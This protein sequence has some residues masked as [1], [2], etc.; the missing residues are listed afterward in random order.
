MKAKLR[1]DEES[2]KLIAIIDKCPKGDGTFGAIEWEAGSIGNS[3]MGLNISPKALKA[4]DGQEMEV[5]DPEKLWDVQKD[6]C[7][8]L[9]SRVMQPFDTEKKVILVCGRSVGKSSS[10]DIVSL[11]TPGFKF[12]FHRGGYEDSMSTCVTLDNVADL[13]RLVSEAYGLDIPLTFKF[14]CQGL[15]RRN[16]W[17]TYLVTC[18]K[19]DL[20]V[21]YTDG[22]PAGA[23]THYPS[24]PMTPETCPNCGSK[25]SGGGT[26]L[27]DEMVS[28]ARVFY[29][30]GASISLRIRPKGHKIIY[31]TNCSA[32]P[33]QV[34]R[35]QVINGKL[36][37][38]EEYGKPL[39]MTAY[40]H[41]KVRE[42]IGLLSS[43]VNGGEQHSDVSREAVRKAIGYL[44]GKGA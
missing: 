13:E 25:Y 22:I 33:E 10:E 38:V 1:F 18:D 7:F 30:C 27:G 23:M 17:K 19:Q 4:M 39:V 43:M 11:F 36:E 20:P 26:G 16:G 34:K 31:L 21:G 40:Q 37:E 29:M 44:N 3:F 28:D 15:D 32:L 12:R 24:A 42:C 2:G 41:M 8:S 14:E 5:K 6:R 35:Y 9:R